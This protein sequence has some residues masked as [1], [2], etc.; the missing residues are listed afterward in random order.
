MS[1]VGWAGRDRTCQ[2]STP[3]PSPALQSYTS[4]TLQS[5]TCSSST[6]SY[7]ASCSLQS[8]SPP[9]SQGSLSP[10]GPGPGPDW[11]PADPA[12]ELAR[13]PA[14]TAVMRSTISYVMSQPQVLTLVLA[15]SKATI[16]SYWMAADVW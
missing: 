1:S 5:S 7:R 15:C 9:F 3:T 6:Q 12:T 11:S 14:H 2:L 16:R 13:P 10:V 8:I 4:P